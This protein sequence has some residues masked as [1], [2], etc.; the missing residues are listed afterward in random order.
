MTER[1][2]MEIAEQEQTTTTT[3][4]APIHNNKL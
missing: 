4:A 2:R 1:K 3:T